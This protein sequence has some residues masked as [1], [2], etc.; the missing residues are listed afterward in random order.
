MR[1]FGLVSKILRI[2]WYKGCSAPLSQYQEYKLRHHIALRVVAVWKA[3]ILWAQGRRP[4][5]VINYF[6][7]W[8]GIHL[9]G[10][11]YLESIATH[12]GLAV[13]IPDQ[14]IE[15]LDT[16]RARMSEH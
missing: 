7:S 5:T 6:A 9:M 1:S 11:S 16:V 3:K 13:V 2:S 12:V 10:G 15:M 4:Q 8:L 14:V